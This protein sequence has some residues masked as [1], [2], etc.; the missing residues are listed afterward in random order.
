MSASDHLNSQQFLYHG[1][2][3][4]V[5]GGKVLPASEHGKGSY[6][7]STGQS[8]GEAAN[9]HAWAVP[10]EERAWNFA[11]DRVVHTSNEH[12]WNPRARVYAVHQNEAQSPG[13]DKSIPGEVKAPHFDVAQR[14]DIMPGRQGTFPEVNWNNHVQHTGLFRENED[15]NHPTNLSVQFGHKYSHEGDHWNGQMRRQAAKEDLARSM[16]RGDAVGAPLAALRT[17][18]PMLPGMEHMKNRF[19]RIT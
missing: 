3:M 19:G 1:T 2:A 9:K 10:D 15:A 7:G 14:H 16:E 12:D 6:W 11:H 4:D 17:K 5:E 8:R 13:H 18:D